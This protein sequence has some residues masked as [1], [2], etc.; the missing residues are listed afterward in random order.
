MTG[1]VVYAEKNPH[2]MRWIAPA[3]YNDPELFRIIT[4]FVFHSLCDGLSSMGRTLNE[5]G[6]SAPWKKPFY[7]NKQLKK[8][9]SNHCLLYSSSSYDGMEEALEKGDLLDGFPSNVQKERVCI[10]DCQKNQFLSVFYHLRNAIAHGRIDIVNVNGECTYIFED[11]AP[12][13]NTGQLKVSA[14]MNLRKNTLLKWIEIIE[15]G[16]TEYVE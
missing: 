9:S 16:E 12:K 1:M 10:Y 14:R 3:E 2:W 4:F 5:Y 11:I 13:R 15:H 8:A 6:W 7:L